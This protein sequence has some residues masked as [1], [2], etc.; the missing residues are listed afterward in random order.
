MSFTAM[1]APLRLAARRLPVSRH[2]LAQSAAA[3]SATALVSS[4][5]SPTAMAMATTS[6]PRFFSSTPLRSNASTTA[7]QQDGQKQVEQQTTGEQLILEL[8]TKRFKPTQLKVQDVS[9]G[10]GSFY[11]IAISSKEFKGLSTIKAHRLVNSV[12]KDV[13][14]DIHGLQLRTIAED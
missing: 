5:A 11:A 14:K 10:C 8:L 13:I 7:T 3:A 1:Q 6:A 2:T 4:S 12:L 9:G